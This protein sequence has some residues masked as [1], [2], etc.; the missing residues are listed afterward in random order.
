MIAEHSS[1]FM[2]NENFFS[3]S[4]SYVC[5]NILLDLA[6]PS[7]IYLNALTISDYAMI[8]FNCAQ[9]GFLVTIMWHGSSFDV[10]YSRRNFRCVCVFL[11]VDITLTIIQTSEH[12]TESSNSLADHFMIDLLNQGN[13]FYVHLTFLFLGLSKNSEPE[14]G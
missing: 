10:L 9:I 11:L 4:I 8:L 6:G 2:K 7:F 3:T 13:N 14:D 12:V 5:F 1:D